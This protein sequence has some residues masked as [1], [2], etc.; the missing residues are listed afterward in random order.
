MAKKQ[1]WKDKYPQ[2][3]FTDVLALETEFGE[4]GSEIEEYDELYNRILAIEKDIKSSPKGPASEIKERIEKDDS[5]QLLAEW[6]G[7]VSSEE[8][9]EEIE[10]DEEEVYIMNQ[11]E[12]TQHRYSPRQEKIIRK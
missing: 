8:E 1:R 9:T 2:A 5:T 12:K 7:Y 3:T 4:S 11:M 10:K 6:A